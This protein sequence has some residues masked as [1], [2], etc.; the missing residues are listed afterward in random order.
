[1]WIEWRE[2]VFLNAEKATALVCNRTTQDQWVIEF[3]LIGEEVPYVR[4]FECEKN[5][6]E[7]FVRLKKKLSP[8]SVLGA[9]RC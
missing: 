8:Y 3:F 4:Y 6:R 5:A 7:E 1:M 2:N 9:M